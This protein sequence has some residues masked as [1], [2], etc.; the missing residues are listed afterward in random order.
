LGSCEQARE[1]RSEAE[2]VYTDAHRQRLEAMLYIFLPTVLGIG[3]AGVFEA[4]IAGLKKRPKR[5]L[6]SSRR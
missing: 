3:A 2:I 1:V 6:K 4:L 5:R